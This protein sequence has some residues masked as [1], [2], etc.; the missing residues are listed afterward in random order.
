MEGTDRTDGNISYYRIA[1]GYYVALCINTNLDY[2]YVTLC[3]DTDEKY[4]S[5]YITIRTSVAL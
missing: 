5:K 2:R 3:I 1:I 4:K